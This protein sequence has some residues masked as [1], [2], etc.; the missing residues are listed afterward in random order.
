[1]EPGALGAHV[2]VIRI[3][4][5]SY[6]PGWAL[7]VAASTLMG[8]YL[9]LGDPR[10]ARRAASY[11]WMLAAAMMGG[12]GILFFA[13]PHT[14]VRMV[15][16]EP[17]LLEMAPPL[18]RI[19]APAQLFLGSSMVLDQAIRGAGDTRTAM[20]IVTGSTFLLRVPAAYLIGVQLGG[21]V[22][23]IWFAICV[24]IS[25][26]AFLLAGYFLSGRWSRVVV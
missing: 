20:C 13:I 12:M 24:E 3:E 4:A 8:Q 17:Q 19:C 16:T 26:R 15:T 7:A 10:R 22:A 2:I 18:L 23:G 21:G 1:M 25:I 6:L 9:G 14:L 5:I 11:C